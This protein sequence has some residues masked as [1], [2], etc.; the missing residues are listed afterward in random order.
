MEFPDAF[1]HITVRGNERR[2]IFCDERDRQSFLG[3][4]ESLVLR[5]KSVIRVYCLMSNH[6]L[7]L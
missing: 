2:D 7:E 3:Y 6:Y 1:Y 5:N 4:L